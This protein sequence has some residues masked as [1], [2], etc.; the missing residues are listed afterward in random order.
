MS[1]KIK[2]GLKLWSAN[3]KLFENAV[4][5]HENTILDFLEL[6]IVPGSYL[7]TKPFFGTLGKLPI[8]I[9]GP[10]FS[11]NFNM[12]DSKLKSTNI[13]KIIE[14]IQFADELNAKYIILHPGYDGNLETSIN[15]LKEIG[16]KRVI[17]ENL[18]KASLSDGECLGHSPEEIT[19]L[20]R[21]ANGLC[22]DLA[23]ACKAAVSLKKNYKTFIKE[24]TKME[25]KMFH[26]SD[27]R[28][29]TEKDEHLPLGQGNFD[30]AFFKK[31]IIENKS[32]MVTFET[33]RKN[34]NSFQEDMENI[35]YFEA[36]Q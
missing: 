14:T 27:G 6:Y 35:R 10:H 31:C 22:L 32:R 18:T 4:K 34:L 33:P 16:D 26:I 13:A 36:L 12:A 21:F 28:L 9:H 17:I 19:R 7:I 5:L 11:H 8:I 1:D 20:V 29:N 25:P 15:F 2:T 3:T 24:F 30:L 23:H